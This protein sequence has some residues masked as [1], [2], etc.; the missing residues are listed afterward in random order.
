MAQRLEWFERG[1]VEGA[2]LQTRE[3]TIILKDL[4]TQ[5]SW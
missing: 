5:T 2:M 3:S 4:P 1:G